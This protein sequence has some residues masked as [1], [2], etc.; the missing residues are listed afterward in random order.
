MKKE[1]KDGAEACEAHVSGRVS[2]RL[3]A[4]LHAKKRVA[5]SYG[6]VIC[7]ILGF[8]GLAKA[9]KSQ[10]KYDSRRRLQ[11]SQ[12]PPSDRRDGGLGT[13]P[14]NKQQ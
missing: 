10:Y 5:S 12:T 3:A 9:H 13:S 2:S 8:L 4:R 1:I 11:A 7:T 14:I 6:R